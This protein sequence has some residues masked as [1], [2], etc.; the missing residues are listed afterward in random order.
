MPTRC[1]RCFFCRPLFPCLPPPTLSGANVLYH[2]GPHARQRWRRAPVSERTGAAGERRVHREGV[3]AGP[4]AQQAGGRH[5]QT[6]YPGVCEQV[7]VRCRVTLSAGC[8][9]RCGYAAG[10]PGTR[11]LLGLVVGSY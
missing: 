10:L 6:R 2:E 4:R 1:E 8:W 7:Q 5:A 3:H 11:C 9:R